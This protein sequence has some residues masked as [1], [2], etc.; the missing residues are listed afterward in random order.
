MLKNVI[1]SLAIIF[2]LAILFLSCS[3]D[4]SPNEPVNK[5]PYLQINLPDS[6]EFG[7]GAEIRISAEASDEDGSISKVEFFVNASSVKSMTESPYFYDFITTEFGAGE[8]IIKAVATDDSGDESED[9]ITLIVS[10][11]NKITMISPLGGEIWG[12][13][14]TKTVL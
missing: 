3:N 2:T 13:G 10:A 12:F 5:Y 4:N 11:G 14:T 1:L 8:H 7:L 9:E 6:L